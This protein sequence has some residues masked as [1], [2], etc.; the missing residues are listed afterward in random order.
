MKTY[1]R[2]RI[3][4]VI[5]I[6][7]LIALEYLEFDGKYKDY[8]ESHDFWELC[9][10][11]NGKA[12]LLSD[13]EKS[14]LCKGNI[15]ITSPGR[16]HSYTPLSDDCKAY[17][18]CFESQS[19]ALYAIAD[20]SFE[21][22]RVQKNCMDI[23]ID[24]ATKTFELNPSDQLQ[25]TA[26]PILGGQQAI[27]TQLEYL[28]IC[29]LRQLSDRENANVIFLSE[30]NFYAGITDIM[31]DYLRQNVRQ[32]LSLTQICRKMNYSRSFIC[33]TFKEQTG[34]TIITYFNKLK[35]DEAKKLLT[36]TELTVSQISQELGFSDPKYF[37]TIFK[38][39]A[40]QTPAAFRKSQK[41]DI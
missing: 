11:E 10:V 4:N 13:G 1:L 26:S 29:T 14:E 17:V 33:K 16:F 37:N 3:V 9:Y 36:E 41:N 30:N 27:L 7:E 39:H 15:I 35:I 25:V 20:C 40:K 2:H 23:I 8:S 5:D 22:T 38:K 18:V 32:K 19:Q 24:E 12:Q 21:L 28:L 31:L 34:E 6:K